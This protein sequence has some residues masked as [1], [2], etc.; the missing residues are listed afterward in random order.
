MSLE[1]TVL[2]AKTAV[3]TLPIIMI[4]EMHFLFWN[5]KKYGAFLIKH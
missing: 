3:F 5:F 4:I 2:F 1:K